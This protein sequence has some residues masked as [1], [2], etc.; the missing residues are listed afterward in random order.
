MN[1]ISLCELSAITVW[2]RSLNHSQ[3]FKDAIDAQPGLKM[4]NLRRSLV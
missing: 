3:L 4:I 1:H 2:K